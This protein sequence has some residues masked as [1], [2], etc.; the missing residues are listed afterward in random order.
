MSITTDGPD[1]CFVCVLPTNIWKKKCL[2]S[3]ATASAGNLA[4]LQHQKQPIP[5]T[6]TF[7]CAGLAR[8]KC[9]QEVFRGSCT[10]SCFVPARVSSFGKPVGKGAACFSK[11]VCLEITDVADGSPERRHQTKEEFVSICSGIFRCM[12]L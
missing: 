3:T 9:F 2:L 10:I 8:H 5:P 6:E 1:A 7:S 4:I 12:N 11:L